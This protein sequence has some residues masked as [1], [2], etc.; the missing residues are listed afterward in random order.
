MNDRLKM[1][2]NDAVW[3]YL[4]TVQNFLGR[5]EDNHENIQESR[6]PGRYSNRRLPKESFRS[7]ALLLESNFAQQQTEIV[8]IK[9]S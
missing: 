8:S 9:K 7:E 6:C 1:I 5:T 2:L 3:P 4:S